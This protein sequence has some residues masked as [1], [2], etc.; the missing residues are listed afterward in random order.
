MTRRLGALF[1]ASYI[2]ACGG[3]D[4][5]RGV[6]ASSPLSSFNVA[7]RDAKHPPEL[8]VVLNDPRFIAA[9]DY[10][11]ARDF[12][13]AAHVVDDERARPP[14]DAQA[15]CAWSYVSGRLH[16]LANESAV[17]AVS[18][19]IV[20]P[21]NECVLA[22]FAT[23]RASQAYAKAGNWQVSLQRAQAIPDDFV[24]HDEARVTLAEALAGTGA[25]PQ[26]VAIWRDLLANHPH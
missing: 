20:V 4:T 23:L 25:R 24:L 14:A 15:V 7:A 6:H 1:I 19:D 9:R 18:F 21:K 17:A 5:L 22:P 11:I 16:A 2:V 13:A 10:Q 8:H 3:G 12:S 26:A